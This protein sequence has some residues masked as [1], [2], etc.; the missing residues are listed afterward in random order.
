MSHRDSLEFFLRLPSEVPDQPLV[1][2]S[3][4]GWH[5]ITHHC[6][7]E[8]LPLSCVES[9]NLVFHKKKE[10]NVKLKQLEAKT[11]RKMKKEVVSLFVRRPHL[12]V[13]AHSGQQRR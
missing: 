13:P 7:Q 12:D 10:K 11:E 8:S 4:L 6:I 1:G 3:I 9:Q 2:E 5:P